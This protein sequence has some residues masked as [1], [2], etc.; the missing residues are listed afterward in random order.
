M[1]ADSAIR[2]VMLDEDHVM[3]LVRHGMAKT[4]IENDAMIRR[5]FAP[6]ECDPNRLYMLAHG[7]SAADG[8]EVVQARGDPLAVA[9]AQVILF[10]RGVVDAATIVSCPGLWLVQR[11]GS[12]SDGID[13]AALRA[14]GVPVSCLARRTLAYT[15]EH[16][17]LLMLALAHRLPDAER[18][19]R[20]GAYD[21]ARV[22]SPDKVAYNWTGLSRVDGLHGRTLGIIGLGEVGALAARMAA[23]FG[24]RV[25]YANR[26]PL[27]PEREAAIGARFRSLNEL[28][29]EADFISI[30]APN[31][32][33]TKDLV[34]ALAI[35]RMKPTAFLV[36][37]ARGPIL[38]EDALYD[39]L[40]AGRIAGAGLDVHGV[41]P[42]P[43]D[44][45]FCALPNVI[46][47]PHI[48]GG[49]RLGLLDEV[50]AIYDNLR[51]V[52]A[53]MPPPHDRVT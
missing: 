18:A 5:F 51:A 12:R 17:I 7:L 33:Q 34:S 31:T 20:S 26:N 4:S 44:D 52:R 46:L 3:A 36:N 6:E 1:P 47:T 29:S 32:P 48:A 13:L 24:M 49:S 40:V 45:R 35:A 19:V 22:I 41:E 16:A 27:P 53:G 43:K 15:A 23:G 25:I 37:T 10:R 42:R 2:I 39:A 50:A 38:D 30:H 8:V 14:R 9:G 11:L 21:P 28:M